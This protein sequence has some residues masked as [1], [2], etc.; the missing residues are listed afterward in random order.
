[1]TIATCHQHINTSII[2]NSLLESKENSLKL[3]Q[4][5]HA[6]L[7]MFVGSKINTEQAFHNT[8]IEFKLGI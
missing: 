3:K 7:A 4:N 8:I 1:V 2:F 6:Q 5:L